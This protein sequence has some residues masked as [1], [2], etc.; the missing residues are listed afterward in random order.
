M[1]HK[2]L[3]YYFNWCF[4]ASPVFSKLLAFYLIILHFNVCLKA[5]IRDYCANIYKI[6]WNSCCISGV[7]QSSYRELSLKIDLLEFCIGNCWQNFSVYALW[8][9]VKGI[10]IKGSPLFFF[11]IA[12]S[13]TDVL[14]AAKWPTTFH[15]LGFR[16]FSRI[17]GML[18]YFENCDCV[19]A[20]L[21]GSICRQV[22][23]FLEIIY[24]S[25]LHW[26]VP[27]KNSPLKNSLEALMSNIA[28]LQY[29]IQ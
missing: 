27:L 26:E 13:N 18:F 8:G 5:T 11:G 16:R 28:P 10:I 12:K 7:K 19:I 3:K 23:H 20:Y 4:R 24:W 6:S 21:C 22:F 29:I 2:T 9:I 15:E 17:C 14:E 25:V 1:Y